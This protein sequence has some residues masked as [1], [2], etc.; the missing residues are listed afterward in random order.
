MKKFLILIIISAYS[1]FG[2]SLINQIP[3]SP[4]AASLGKYGESNTNLATGTISP[5]I[6]LFSLD[7]Y[8]FPFQVSLNYRYQGYRPSEHVGV[9]G[10]GWSI[11]AGGTITRVVNGKKDELP[12]GY[13]NNAPE[14]KSAIEAYE[15]SGFPS[16][17]I[18]DIGSGYNDGEPDIF[19]FNFGNYSGSFF[20]G[21]DEKFHLNSQQ[22]IKIETQVSPNV[23]AR[24]YPIHWQV[25]QNFVSFT[26]TTEDG[27]IYKFRDCEYSRST[28]YNTIENIVEDGTNGKT[29]SAWYLSEIIGPNGQQITFEYSLAPALVN[30]SQFSY[31]EYHMNFSAPGFSASSFQNDLVMNLSHEIYLLAIKGNGW[32]IELDY[33]E[34]I[35]QTNM[36]GF[37]DK[38]KQLT[39]IDHISLMQE[40]P[41]IVK[42]F[43]LDYYQY[44]NSFALKTLTEVNAENES[45]PPHEFSYYGS[46]FDPN[47]T[48]SIDNFG[49]YNGK[50][51]Y[52]L[53]PALGA[54]RTPSREHAKRGALYDI[55]Y[56]TGGSTQYTHE[57]NTYSFLD[58]EPQLGTAYTD[59]SKLFQII[60]G[61][62]IG[63]QLLYVTVPILID[64]NI[65][66]PPG[67]WT[68]GCTFPLS[69]SSHTLNPKSGNAPYTSADI[70][71][72]LNSLGV[73]IGTPATNPEWENVSIRI[74]ITARYPYTTGTF[75][76]PGIRI[77]S[78][79]QNDNLGLEPDIVTTYEYRQATGNR[80]SGEIYGFPYYGLWAQGQTGGGYFLSSNSFH[81]MSSAPINYLRVE[82]KVNN[83]KKAEYYFTGHASNDYNNVKGTPYNTA[84][85][86]DIG[87]FSDFSSMRGKLS[88]KYTFADSLILNTQ[89][90]LY[91]TKDTYTTGSTLY[92]S[93]PA[94][95][96]QKF[97]QYG[98][99]GIEFPITYIKFYHPV[100]FWFY[101]TQQNMISYDENGENPVNSATE[102]FYE[103]PGHLQ[104]TRQKHTNSDGTVREEH[105]KYPLDYSSVTG[106]DPIIDS[107]INNYRINTIIESTVFQNAQV[108]DATAYTFAQHSGNSKKARLFL[109]DKEYRFQAAGTFVPYSGSAGGIST[110]SYYENTSYVAYDTLGQPLQ[111]R[112]VSGTNV[113]LVRAYRGRYPIAVAVNA[114]KTEIDAVLAYMG[115][116]QDAL[117]NET[118]ESALDLAINGLQTYLPQSYVNGYLF[119][120]FVGMQKK[121]QP[122]GIKTGFVFDNFARL[123]GIKNHN[124]HW[125]Q[126]Y[127]YQL[128]GTST[129]L[130]NHVISRNLRVA[131]FD[132]T[133]ASDFQKAQT[134]MELFNAFGLPW[135]TLLWRQSPA[136][137]NTISQYTTRDATGRTARTYLPAPYASTA[138]APDNEPHDLIFNFYEQQP[139]TTNEYY[140]ASDALKNTKG[141]GNSWLTNNKKTTHIYGT[142]G[143][144]I[145]KYTINS[146][147]D[148]TLSWTHLPFTF[149]STTTI[150][151]QGN[152]V[153]EYKDKR[154]LTVQIRVKISS[155]NYAVTNYI[156]DDLDR[157]RAVIQ[158]EGFILGASIHSGSPAFHSYVFCYEYDPRGRQIRKH[159]P[160][161]GWTDL[162]YDRANRPVMEQNAHQ[163]TLNKW[164]FRQY[165]VMNREVTAGETTKPVT[166]AAAQALFDAHT[167]P[168]E[169]RTGASYN[170]ASFPASLMPLATEAVLTHYYDNYSFA[171]AAFAFEPSGA[172]HA[173]A[174]DVKGMHTGTKKTNLNNTARHYM[175]VNYYDELGREIQT[176]HTTVKSSGNTSDIITRNKEY[177]FAGEVIRE[178]QNSPFSTGSVATEQ[179]NHYDHGARVTSI[180]YG[181][182][183]ADTVK[184]VVYAHDGISRL[185]QKKFM[186]NGTYLIG[187]TSDYIYRS[188]SPAGSSTVDAARKAVI[189]EPNTTLM[190]NYVAQIDTLPGWGIPISGLQT[191]DYSWHIRGGLHGINLN[192]TGNPTP[193]LLQGDLL[194]YKLDY[195]TAGQ[196]SGNI[197]RQTWDHVQGIQLAGLRNYTFTYDG[198]DRLKTA[199]YSGIGT[200]NY[201]LPGINYDKNGNIL[202]LQRNG[203]TGSSEGSP[204][205]GLI[206]DLTYSYSGNR[207]MRVEDA[208]GGEHEVDFINRNTGSDDYEYYPNGALKK[209]LN[210]DILNI[211]Y[212]TFLNKEEEITLTGGRWIK[213][214]YD[215]SGSLIKTEYSTGEYWE[216]SDKFVFK[217]GQP[218]QM[219]IPEGRAIFDGGNW[220]YEFDYKDH[221]GNTRVSFKADGN[222]LVQT[223]KSD[224]DPFLVPLK[225]GQ[226][227]SFQNRWEVQG[228]EKEMTFN[229][230]RINFG[231]RNYNPTIGR[232]DRNDNKAEKYLGLSPYNYALN[233]SLRYI[234]PD[235]NKPVDIIIILQRDA[236]G[237]R[238]EVR[239]YQGNLYNMDGSNYK[240]DMMGHF[241]GKIQS[242]LNDIRSSDSYLEKIVST[243]ESSDAGNHYIELTNSPKAKN[244]VT[245]SGNQG[246]TVLTLRY[247]SIKDGKYK[248]GEKKTFGTTMS[249]ELSHQ[250]DY[251]TGQHEAVK[252]GTAPEKNPN[253]IRAVNTEN[254]YRHSKDIEPRTHY[255]GKIDQSKLEDPKKEK[256]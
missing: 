126:L 252:K 137:F 37:E 170:G 115:T 117:R 207:L 2:Q 190:P 148:I 15:S 153:T 16:S 134:R 45:L 213:Y 155:E 226:E 135:Q 35:G 85:V 203:K 194:S 118:G 131:T 165:D 210:E 120:P 230:N 24:D 201:S 50:T 143:S 30:R 229:L 76:G 77:A 4:N 251:E 225:T 183:G 72:L 102:L 216:F 74:N 18:T 188:S 129:A 70:I 192:A 237:G 78:I 22:K 231:A 101:P 223:A 56:P 79:V 9:T 211:T 124:N 255:R 116:S 233:N 162:V 1:A 110:A 88:A 10:R 95:Y 224:F 96:V 125:S 66:I 182:N 97:A 90:T 55:T 40:S 91:G 219:A 59:T 80:S 113:S 193:N 185:T 5:S 242:T 29:I 232:W 175:E 57:L 158:P 250:Y 168:Y 199:V 13:Y 159:I 160:G 157:L 196:W 144:F 47:L 132:S 73:C 106:K 89:E 60:E 36:L 249:H 156:Y 248:S 48:Q 164:K 28:T 187:S 99:S 238:S 234:D 87:P 108:H 198:S 241:A 240:P 227:N 166:R 173:Q 208:I 53:I 123:S 186:P 20:W 206:D 114:Q 235:G 163:K 23:P 69:I 41:Q 205:F 228:K 149:T 189:I 246:S 52:T 147:N 11:L 119:K 171:P 75:W 49:Y 236:Q 245:T 109:P 63:S 138:L 145:S 161:A 200:E 136:A 38:M 81:G 58:G 68:P 202:N 6:P 151:E 212:N 191:I 204:T 25:L 26:L 178:R 98:T 139:Y 12:N 184:I 169:T 218:Y 128:R 43:I 247:D 244:R 121:I 39:R 140:G 17:V 32:R 61:N 221:L 3:P 51:N 7:E 111:L 239:Y 130:S 14:I 179:H 142:A 65:T 93:T 33:E 122:N 172:F 195:E 92:Y 107:L 42:S 177:N 100:S 197:G 8:G 54:I 127:S 220:I 209:D 150:N 214:N 112:D 62:I 44:Y 174:P 167:T 176:R 84:S 83:I 215:G 133:Q 243:L 104:L 105:F 103:N 181:I 82:E 71:A 46:S 21:A 94:L 154:G 34:F 31:L 86:N 256:Q 27:T 146:N 64:I 67:S 152:T 254:R 253:E 141:T 222:R 180:D 217:N 19:Y